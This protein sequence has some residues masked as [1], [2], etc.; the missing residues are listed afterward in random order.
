MGKPNLHIMQSE[1]PRLSMG[2]EV[3]S[4]RYNV[5]NIDDNDIDQHW[6]SSYDYAHLNTFFPL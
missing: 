4:I 1:D 3:M 5:S 2:V 6:T